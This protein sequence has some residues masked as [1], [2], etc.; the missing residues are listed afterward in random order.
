MLSDSWSADC[1]ARYY[2]PSTGRFITQDSY[3]GSKADPISMNRYAYASDNPERYADPS[4]HVEVD[5]LAH[6]AQGTVT[7]TTSTQTVLLRGGASTLTGGKVT[8]SDESVKESLTNSYSTTASDSGPTIGISG[9]LPG[10]SSNFNP[11]LDWNSNAA[12]SL[13][14]LVGTTMAATGVVLTGF[15]GGPLFAGLAGAATGEF[16]YL[17]G[18]P[19]PTAYGSPLG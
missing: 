19:P 8:A 1:G 9:S 13:L 11:W 12:D 14:I 10:S 17:D 16:V 6:D 2:D 5:I 3:P 15:G 18:N 7:L 4:G